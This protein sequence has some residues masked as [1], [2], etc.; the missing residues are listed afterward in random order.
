MT[1]EIIKDEEKI[2]IACRRYSPTCNF[3]G[4]PANLLCDYSLINT[5]RKTCDLRIC[6]KCTTKLKDK[7]ICPSHIRFMKKEGIAL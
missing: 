1:C 7:D 3:C 5:S 2:T 6:S 4:T